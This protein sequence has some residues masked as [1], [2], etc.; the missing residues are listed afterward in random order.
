MFGSGAHIKLSIYQNNYFLRDINP[1]NIEESQNYY[2]NANTT[3]DFDNH[4]GQLLYQTTDTGFSFT[5]DE[6]NGDEEDEKAA[7][8]LQVSLSDF[9]TQFWEDLL[10]FGEEGRAELSNANNFR[11]YFRGLYFKAEPLNG[12][13]GSM[14]MLDFNNAYIIVNYDHLVDIETDERDDATFR[15]NF[16]G[17]RVNI[18]ENDPTNSLISDA[19]AMA[20]D[21][22][23]DQSLYLKGG[24]GSMAV[25]ELFDGDDLDSNTSIDNAFEAFKK[26][27]AEV[28]DTT[29]AF[30]EPKR[31]INEA[32]LV[33]YVDQNQVTT[34][35]QEPNRVILYDLENNAPLIDY[36]LDAT[37]N[38]TD[39]FNSKIFHSNI[40]SRDE[41]DNGIRYKI[42]ITEHINN[43]ILKDSS[44][45]KLGLFVSTN[46]N[47]IENSVIFDNENET[48]KNLPAGAVIAPKGTIL[49][50][51]NP[52]VAEEKRVQLEIFY[53][54]P[55]NE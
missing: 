51:S 22:E 32:N 1:D 31:L 9:S 12:N 2:S 36:F 21:T 27:F 20:N 35:S 52:N 45:V 8:G 34:P 53:T 46:V 55:E 30:L 15:F 54:E 23:G 24:E 39:P 47:E 3:I 5:S 37:T 28:D 33:F 40:L 43:L 44:N 7:P 25:V 6:I 48:V 26:A 50:G 41:N 10:F 29:G 49:Y 4:V 14:I 42:R 18:I 11:E 17:T 13:D 16:I 19:D 38:G